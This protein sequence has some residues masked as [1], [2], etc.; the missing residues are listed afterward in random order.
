MPEKTLLR[1][2]L[3]NYVQYKEYRLDDEVP[4]PT[5][6][7]KTELEI[8]ILKKTV[9][10]QNLLNQ[11]KNKY[12]DDN[13]FQFDK[14]R[15]TFGF[16][17]TAVDDGSSFIKGEPYEFNL[18]SVDGI[19]ELTV[20]YVDCESPEDKLILNLNLTD[21]NSPFTDLIHLNCSCCKFVDGF[22]ISNR[23]SFIVELNDCD[24]YDFV[25]STETRNDKK[26]TSYTILNRCN[27]YNLRGI[28][29]NKNAY[30]KIGDCQVKSSYTNDEDLDVGDITSPNFL[31]SN[32]EDVNIDKLYFD[33]FISGL[34]LSGNQSVTVS[35]LDGKHT[36]LMNPLQAI[37][38][39]VGSDEVNI[40]NCDIN[41]INIIDCG[42][43]CVANINPI[44]NKIQ[45]ADYIVKIAGSKDTVSLAEINPD[46]NV[47]KKPIIIAMCSSENI[48]ICS[49]KFKNDFEE[50][51]SVNSNDG[52]ISI[53]DCVFTNNEHICIKAENISNALRFIDC[54]F[55]S[56]KDIISAATVESLDFVGCTIKGANSIN[57]KK[58][59][60]I[61]MCN[62]VR[63]I[64]TYFQF[65]NASIEDCGTCD[66][67]ESQFTD[68]Y[69]DTVR[70][71]ISSK[72]SLFE[73][74]VR[75]D[76]SAG[77][78][79]TYGSSINLSET[80]FRKSPPIIYGFDLVN[81]KNSSFKSGLNISNSGIPSSQIK[82][83]EF[84]DSEDLNRFNRGIH[85]EACSSISIIE[86]EF[87]A[88]EKNNPSI[89]D[90]IWCN[91]CYYDNTNNAPNKSRIN[92]QNGE[93][94]Y[95]N[96]IFVIDKTSENK[97]SINTLSNYSYM[98]YLFNKPKYN[99]QYS[100]M[101]AYDNIDDVI[102]LK[103]NM[104]AYVDFEESWVEPF[105][106]KVKSNLNTGYSNISS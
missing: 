106:A 6:S 29:I 40:S 80:E 61:S 27:F 19:G 7:Y 43:I 60:K 18:N 68:S 85:L 14:I 95:N 20:I 47:A 69:I 24:I 45:N 59:L 104:V 3:I 13:I 35:F 83:C 38:G 65:I 8:R 70:T 58:D 10:V 32:C 25:E 93:S 56:N 30:L 33:K 67:K 21:E 97:P 63:F 99:E 81:L 57:E 98:L 53:T 50:S 94:N 37:L 77:V 9:N 54:I 66:F 41:G 31:I 90:M 78:A 36:D 87:Y 71:D 102:K 96:N 103:T 91:I 51:I 76:E 39:I 100:G 34:Q 52:I 89:L 73:T 74:T 26:A 82:G 2:T 17:I 23:E 28:S 64:D 105:L 75:I 62:T 12:P 86:N 72:Q 88:L 4:R 42:K 92:I 1:E 48:G 44:R 101:N 46:I 22:R 15:F 49:C 55:D 16:G 79:F 84:G 5:G 11:W